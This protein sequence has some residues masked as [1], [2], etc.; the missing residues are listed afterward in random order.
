MINSIISFFLNLWYSLKEKISEIVNRPRGNTYQSNN[1]PYPSNNQ[2]PPQRQTR[3][4]LLYQQQE[5]Q[6]AIFILNEQKKYLE[7]NLKSINAN[8]NAARQEY[9]SLQAKVK[10]AI[11]VNKRT[12]LEKSKKEFYKLQLSPLD[13]KEISKVREIE[14]YF[15]DASALNKAIWSVYYKK[16]ASD[17]VGRVVG[18]KVK[19]GIYKITNIETGQCYVG[20]SVDIGSRFIQHIKRGIGAESATRNKLYP[21]MKQIGPENFT[22]E[23]IE[24]CN[25]AELNKKELEWQDFY[26]AKEF[27]YSER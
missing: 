1:Y 21:A 18:N 25:K 6:Q 5:L 4:Q 20:Q 10:A 19:T 2:M 7:E 3:Q 16:A 15:R 26:G 17:L 13:I 24:E 22:F 11:E 8:Y 27:G 23:I 9:N 12:A 14:P